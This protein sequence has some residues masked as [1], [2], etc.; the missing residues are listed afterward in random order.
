MTDLKATYETR[1]KELKGNASRQKRRLRQTSLL[2]MAVFVGGCYLVYMA[3][4]GPFWYGIGVLV[5]TAVFIYLVA[6]HQDLKYES[7]RLGELIR[8]NQTELEVL[9]GDFKHLPDGAA[10]EDADHAFAEDLDLF[11][12][13]SFFQYINRTGMVS[14]ASVL[15]KWLCS[16][17]ISGIPE[18]QEAIRELRDQV[19]WRQDF[20]ATARLISAPLSTE[21]L[22]DWMHDYQPHIPSWSKYLPLGFSVLSL[23]LGFLVV[24][25]VLPPGVL[26]A[27]FFT[28]LLITLPF[29]RKIGQLALT[30]GKTQETFSQYQRLVEQVEAKAFQSLPLR[31]LRGQ[32]D[33]TDRSVSDILKRFSRLIGAL[34]QRNNLLVA[35]FGNAFF[36]WDLR[37]AYAVEQEIGTYGNHTRDW[38]EAL[39][40]FDAWN[41]LSNFAFN[42]PGYC[43]P[44]MAQEK[45][46][47]LQIRQL[48]HPLLRGKIV[49]NDIGIQK[50]HFMVITGANMAGKSTFLRAVSL[51]VLMANTGLPVCAE[52]MVYAPVPLITSMRTTDSLSRQESYFFAEL[53][54]L[55]VIVD[56]LKEGPYFVVLD[57][58]LKGTNSKDKARGS[59]EFLSRLLITA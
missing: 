6:R 27:L 26:I 17:D 18:K 52:A 9:G 41:S 53:K 8:V 4:Q 28:G 21:Q 49:H 25:G 55:K 32:L 24:F 19:E 33:E 36:L 14:G 34:D 48:A 30:T 40:A 23:V 59:K 38:F 58:I 54:R 2:R 57:E 45:E 20:T 56:H 16:N 13:S 44:E 35:V 31:N 15:A 39:S 51:S 7:K 29:A 50:G 22:T 11:G 47:S 37:Q 3:L 46:L 12:P 43:F 42:H 1:L 10:F 5:M